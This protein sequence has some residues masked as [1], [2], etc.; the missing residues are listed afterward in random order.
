MKKFLTVILALALSCMIPLTAL[1]ATLV[2]T[3][4][5]PEDFN[6]NSLLNSGNFSTYSRGDDNYLHY[7]LIN[8]AGEELT[9]HYY[10]IS[11]DDIP[12]YSV[13]IA[14]TGDNEVGLLNNATGEI[15]VPAEYGYVDTVSDK[16][17]VGIHLTPSSDPDAPY[18]NFF[19]D[20]RYDVVDADVYFGAQK[21]VTLTKEEWGNFLP[22]GGYLLIQNNTNLIWLDAAGEKRVYDRVSSYN[23]QYYEDYNTKKITHNGSG[24]EAFVPGCTLT[25]D[26]VDKAFWMTEAGIVDLQGNVIL[27]REAFPHEDLYLNDSYGDYLCISCYSDEVSDS[28]YGVMDKTGKIIIPCTLSEVPDLSPEDPW[29]ENGILPAITADNHLNFYDTTGA[30]LSSIDLTAYGEDPDYETNGEIT[31]IEYGDDEIALIS[32]AKGA[33]DISA[34]EEIDLHDNGLVDVMQNDLWGVMDQNG[35]LIIPCIHSSSLTVTE[36]GTLALGRYDDENDERVTV[37]YAIEY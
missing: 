26:E 15:I 21:L 36:D 12:G 1:G 4:K 37:L 2:S 19:N 29:F 20:S 7:W 34:Y 17:F 33:I 13:F 24:Q 8:A 18:R 28:L 27:A 10:D 22:Y 3:T 11:H 35:E 30:V 9:P 25:P 14:G 6:S 31:L 16:W 32:T 5:L 23:S